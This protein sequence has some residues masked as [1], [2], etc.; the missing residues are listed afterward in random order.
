MAASP[1]FGDGEWWKSAPGSPPS[2]EFWNTWQ[3]ALSDECER[4]ST[5]L[6]EGDLTLDEFTSR[7]F[8]VV[9]DG[10]GLGYMLGRQRAGDLT[11]Y[12]EADQTT[13][14]IAA[15]FDASY[16]INWRRQM[17]AGDDRYH[18]EDGKFKP[19]P[20]AQRANLY[21]QRMRG[22][23]TWGWEQSLPDETSIRWVMTKTENCPDCPQMAAQNPWLPGEMPI[24]PGEFRTPCKQNCGCRLETDDFENSY[25]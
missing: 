18:D 12:S 8:S 6:A 24:V 13:G 7:L 23:A 15:Q 25:E 21:M 2:Q 22:T 3:A 17:E 4:L 9:E 1:L 5:L 16:L 19:E 10:H 14:V 20:I 11:A